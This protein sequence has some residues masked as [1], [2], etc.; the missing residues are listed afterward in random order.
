[1]LQIIDTHCHLVSEKLRDNLSIYLQNAEKAGVK[2][3]INVAYNLESS[4]LVL[5]QIKTDN[6]LYG[7]L[8]IQPLDASEYTYDVAEKIKTLA[9][10][11]SKIVAIGEIGLDAYYQK[12]NL[13]LQIEA[14]EHFLD[15]ACKINLPIIVHVRETHE[16]V[17]NSISKYIKQGLRGVIHCFTGTQKEAFQ[18]LD[19]GF[20]ISFAGIVTFKNAQN[21]AEVAKS[22]P[23]EKILIETDSPYLA[24]VPMR[25][26]VNEPAY[27]LHTCTFL[28]NLR[29]E[30][31]ENFAIQTYQNSHSLFRF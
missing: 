15:I 23:R 24:P 29:S 12:D 9:L 30:S 7:A 3:I 17:H 8:G 21:L 14:F 18:F 20:Y 27:L 11:S 22:I 13:N 16:H 4:E 10:S 1:M 19:C 25:G 2:K 26:K 6:M 31:L 5:K 28:A